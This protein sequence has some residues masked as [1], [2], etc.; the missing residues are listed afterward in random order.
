MA[1][2][3][4]Q[5]EAG[6]TLVEI[7][8]VL[9]VLGLT[10]GLVVLN[11]PQGEDPFDERIETYVAQFNILQQDSYIDGKTRGLEINK[12]GFELFHYAEDWSYLT[13]QVWGD[14][15]DVK[16]VI[17]DEIIDFVDRKKIIDDAEDNILPPL[18][19]FDPLEGVTD[20]E[21]E[22]ETQTKTYRLSPDSRGKI[23]ID[24][25]E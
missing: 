5:N 12:D 11:L 10:A 7:M 9:V 3:V 21:L 17:E 23:T 18:I 24:F 15:F 19:R 4:E 14:V 16:L 2:R 6:F 20:F 8:C 1:I 13:E 25:V 22:I